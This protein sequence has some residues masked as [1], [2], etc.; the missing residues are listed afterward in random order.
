MK[1]AI[2]MQGL[3][4]SGKSTWSQREFPAAIRCSADD[5]FIG[6]DG[7]YN[8]DPSQLSEAHASCL[9]KFLEGL[10]RGV[11][12]VVCDNTNLSLWELAPYVQ[13]A[14]ALGYEVRVVR[15]VVSPETAAQRNVHGVPA[16]A[17]AGMAKRLEKPLPFW[18]CSFEQIETE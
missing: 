10:S 13:S 6:A 3:P 8:F 9:R 1:Q 16:T 11:E 4:G 2:I 15:C 5:Y 12:T 18:S 14:A 17:V 7:S